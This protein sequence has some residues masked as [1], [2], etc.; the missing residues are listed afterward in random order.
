MWQ[1]GRNVI[2][3]ISE[4]IVR[5]VVGRGRGG[6]RPPTFFREGWMHPPLPP[7]FVLK[8]VQKLVHC[9]NR[10]LTET[11]Y[12]IISVQHVCR[13]ELFKNLCLSLVSGVPH[14][15][16]WDYTPSYCTSG[17]LSSNPRNT[18]KFWSWFLWSNA[19]PA[20]CFLRS[21]LQHL[22]Q[23]LAGHKCKGWLLCLYCVDKI[24]ICCFKAAAFTK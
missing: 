14:F 17:R 4:G 9:C 3:C 24:L 13:P 5:G 7:L 12:K 2:A 10:L 22:Y 19:I 1:H 23:S 18:R 6:R 16:F 11:Q 8:F 20:I 15:F 21:Q